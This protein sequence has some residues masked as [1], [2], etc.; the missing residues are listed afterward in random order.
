MPINTKT[1]SEVVN[2]T[3][4]T[5]CEG[6]RDGGL[7]K[8]V[9]AHELIHDAPGSTGRLLVDYANGNVC[10]VQFEE[11]TKIAQSQLA[12]ADAATV[13]SNGN[14]ASTHGKM[15]IVSPVNGQ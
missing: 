10:M 9:E 4:I 13:S 7:Q 15:R 8:L 6:L 5:G 11:R 3:T 1:V 2:R 12:A 14:G